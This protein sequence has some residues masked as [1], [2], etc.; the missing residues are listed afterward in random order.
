MAGFKE[1]KPDVFFVQE[2]SQLL[3]SELR[4]SNQYI[5]TDP[6]E[7]SLILLNRDSFSKF[8]DF[9]EIYKEIN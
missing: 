9:S 7:D 5:V 3:L 2:Y 4:K 8:Q 6:K 1:L